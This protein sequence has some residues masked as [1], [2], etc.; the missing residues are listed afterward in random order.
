MLN[1]S[2]SNTDL[3]NLTAKARTLWE[4]D[5]NSTP[6][7]I[8]HRANAVAD[9]VPLRAIYRMVVEDWTKAEF[10]CYHIPFSDGSFS[11]VLGLREG[12]DIPVEDR[13]FIENDMVLFAPDGRTILIL[14]EMDRR[15]WE[16]TWFNLTS[17]TFG[18]LGLL[19]GL[20]G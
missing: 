5:F 1:Q 20:I 13:R 12:W 9:S 15:W 2:Y 4:Y 6:K 10:N 7:K 18:A 8:K 11:L 19:F 14:P 17:W 3:E 16:T